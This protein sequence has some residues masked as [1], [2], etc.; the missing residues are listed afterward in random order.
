MV[1]FKVE[2]YRVNTRI[3][4][5]YSTKNSCIQQSVRL[6]R[7]SSRS[8]FYLFLCWKL[9]HFYR[10]LYF[11]EQEDILL[12]KNCLAENGLWTGALV[13]IQYAHPI[14]FSATLSFNCSITGFSF[15]HKG[16]LVIEENDNLSLELQ[17]TS[18]IIFP[19]GELVFSNA[20]IVA[21]FI[22]RM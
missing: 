18:C 14:F 7:I 15:W 22:D 11:G 13:L 10:L 12:M 6:R 8:C 1:A 5:L 20:S 2:P 17:T 19:W 3:Q 9:E 16:S 4:S 21:S